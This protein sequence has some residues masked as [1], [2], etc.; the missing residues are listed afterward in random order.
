VA[1]QE[2]GPGSVN[3]FVPVIVFS[4]FA[5]L[6]AGGSARKGPKAEAQQRARMALDS[7]LAQG[8]YLSNPLS[9]PPLAGLCSG[10]PFVLENEAPE[11]AVLLDEGRRK[12]SL[13]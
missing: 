11:G 5:P 7:I 4:A 2:M 3:C 9:E 13:H 1:E 12:V 8:F 10:G 6:S